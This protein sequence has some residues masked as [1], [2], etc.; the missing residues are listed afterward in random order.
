LVARIGAFR[1]FDGGFT[2][3]GTVYHAHGAVD[4]LSMSTGTRIIWRGH[5]HIPRLRCHGVAGLAAWLQASGSLTQHL[6]RHVGPVTLQRL[7]QGTGM[8][9]IDEADA[10]GLAAVAGHRVHVREVLLRCGEQPLVMARSVCERRHLSGPWRALKG[11]GSR[12]LAELLFHDREVRRLPLTSAY[13]APHSRLG[14]AQAEKWTKATGMVWPSVGLW[15]RRSIFVRRGA[16][17]LV[18]EL[19]ALPMHQI[20]GPRRVV[21]PTP[22][23]RDP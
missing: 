23:V 2:G 6:R 9:R 17:L 5:P 18:A 19:F 16:A 1:K 8:A 11:L 15:Q 22:V 3:L 20:P 12:P 7:R 14:R 4:F 13:L 21:R 10:L